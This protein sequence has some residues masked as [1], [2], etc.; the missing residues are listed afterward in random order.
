MRAVFFGTPAI[1]VPSLE[2]LARVAQVAAVV[3]QPDRPAGRG[4]QV[5]IPPVK[6]CAER[7]GIPVV[8]PLKLRTPDFA[9]WL[10]AQQAD[11]AVVLAYGRIL[12]LQVLT[13]PRLGCLNLHASLLPRYRGAAPIQWAIVRGETETGISLMQMDEGLDT[14]PVFTIRSTPIGPDETAGELADRLGSLAAELLEDAL[15]RVLRGELTRVPQ[16]DGRATLAPILKKEDGAID[17]IK[18]AAAVHDHVRG[19]TPWP[20]AFTREPGGKLLKILSTH[21]S[22]LGAPEGTEPG[23]VVLSDVKAAASGAGGCVLV[24]CGGGTVIE[25]TRAQLEGRKPLGAREL[26]AGR[27]LKTGMKLSLS[28]GE[29]P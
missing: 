20:G 14:G 26:V 28:E 10:R 24:A 29:K 22:D 8:Q 21:R 23:T 17:W 4:L 15:P 11:V 1:A 12:P 18:P 16:D 5:A 25:I 6:A 19:M 7:L 13:A 9:E 2:A 3:C 27:V